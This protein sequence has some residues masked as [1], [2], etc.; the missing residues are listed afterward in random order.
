MR[1]FKE[2]EIKEYNELLDR[3]FEPIGLNI[4]ELPEKKGKCKMILN[5]RDGELLERV[6]GL[7]EIGDT[8]FLLSEGEEV[9]VWDLEEYADKVVVDE[10]TDQGRWDVYKRKVLKFGDKFL[11]LTWS[12]GATENQDYGIEDLELKEVFPHEE[13][14]TV[15]K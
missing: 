8:K 6:V 14:I 11:E 4:F 2:E 13:T 5:K 10:I 12:Q 1:D 15:Y 3:L 9:D 7:I